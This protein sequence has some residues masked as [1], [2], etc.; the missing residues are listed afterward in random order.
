MLSTSQINTT[1]IQY[2]SIQKCDYEWNGFASKVLLMFSSMFHTVKRKP[3]WCVMSPSY[4]INIY[5]YILNIYY[6]HIIYIIYILYIYCIYIY[7]YIYDTNID[8][9]IKMV[10]VQKQKTNLTR[11][12]PG[13]GYKRERKPKTKVKELRQK[14]NGKSQQWGIEKETEEESNNKKEKRYSISYKQPCVKQSQ[15]RQPWECTRSMDWQI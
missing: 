1:V 15:K 2:A 12:K 5:I 9:H 6:I 14:K 3:V 7:I 10:I 4:H 13:S 11:T 8:I